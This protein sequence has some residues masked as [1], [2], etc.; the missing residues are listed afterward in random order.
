MAKRSRP[1]KSSSTLSRKEVKPSSVSLWRPH[2]RGLLVD[3]VEELLELGGR[4]CLVPVLVVGGE[5][6]G[7]GELAA[8]LAALGLCA[9]VA[10]VV[11]GDV[12]GV[13]EQLLDAVGEAGRGGFGLHADAQVVVASLVRE[14]LQVVQRALDR[15]QPSSRRDGH[16]LDVGRPLGLRVEDD[17]ALLLLLLA[18]VELD[19]GAGIAGLRGG[20]D[21]L[22]AVEVAES[23]VLDRRRELL[24]VDAVD[25]AEVQLALPRA[26]P[27]AVHQEVREDDVDGGGRE[28]LHERGQDVLDALPVGVEPLV[29]GVH[30]RAGVH[31]SPLRDERQDRDPRLFLAVARGERDDAALVGRPHLGP[32]VDPQAFEEGRERPELLRVVVVAGDQDAGDALGHEARQEVVDELLRLGRGRR[33]VEDVAR[34]ED[35]VHLAVDR[36]PGHLT[37][38]PG[39]LV[40]PRAAPQ[41]LAD[42][43]VGGVEEAHGAQSIRAPCPEGSGAPIRPNK[44]PVGNV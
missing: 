21:L 43:P 24:G 39:V 7:G 36:D 2:L 32:D 13:R 30:H 5:E 11:H 15:A 31:H 26:D 12:E 17:D 35:G 4:R 18:E 3:R 33:R 27:R 23:D 19:Q 37:E 41:R 14:A 25:L 40:H 9:C 1:E 22:R 29:L 28:A 38:G 34:D 8:A 16:E 6:L 44:R 42:V 10:R 20:Q